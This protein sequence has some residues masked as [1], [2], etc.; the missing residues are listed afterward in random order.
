LSGVEITSAQI[1]EIFNKLE[2]IELANARLDSQTKVNS[3]STEF[4]IK[5]SENYKTVGFF[6]FLLSIFGFFLWYI[7]L[8]RY[9]D[10]SVK[11]ESKK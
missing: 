8:Q 9:I 11:K 3:Y 7:K 2:P 4:L 6:G 10:L 1:E 5:Q